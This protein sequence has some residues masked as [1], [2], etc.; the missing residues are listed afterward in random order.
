MTVRSRDLG[1]GFHAERRGQSGTTGLEGL[2]PLRADRETTPRHFLPAPASGYA[3]GMPGVADL[4]ELAG[5]TFVYAF[6]GACAGKDC[7]RLLPGLMVAIN[8]CE[9]GAGRIVPGA[10]AE[11]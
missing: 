5:E 9:N 11:I 3:G 7:R 4:P 6:A 2:P 1:Y 10:S 8:R